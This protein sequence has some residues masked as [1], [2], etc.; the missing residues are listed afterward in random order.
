M[1]TCNNGQTTT[2]ESL[3]RFQTSSVLPGCSSSSS[4]S[5]SHHHHHD[6]DLLGLPAEEMQM[7]RHPLTLTYPGLSHCH[8]P[9]TR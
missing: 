8:P 2:D 7:C 6:A 4:S 3:N 9:S 1:A 5:S